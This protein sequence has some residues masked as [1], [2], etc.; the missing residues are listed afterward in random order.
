M[1]IV[2]P[3]LKR[4]V[5]PSLSKTGILRHAS[6]KG[7]AV[8]TYHGV[9]P[10]GYQ[11]IDEA[12]DGNLVT[13]EQL[14][15]QLRFLK[16]RYNVV[17]P[18]D[19]LAWREGRQNLPERAV[20]LTCDDGLLNHLTCLA[21]VLQE[22]KVSCLFFVTGAS[23]A[24]SRTMLWYE[25]MFLLFLRSP[26]GFHQVSCSGLVAD[27]ELHS[28]EQRRALWWSY[29][30]RLS[31]IDAQLRRNFL[32]ALE[33]AL[34]SK[35]LEAVSGDDSAFRQRFALLT[36]DEVLALSAA[37]MTIGAHTMS[38]PVLSQCSPDEAQNE[39]A[40]CRV[41]L[42]SVLNSRVWAFAYPFGDAQ[43]VT[44][45]VLKLPEAAGYAVAFMNHGGG[46]GVELPPFAFPRIHVT[47]QTN[48]AELEA[49]VSGFYSG[50]H[51]RLR[52]SA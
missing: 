31:K 32:D 44:P 41:R 49:H 1:K 22:E 5:Y 28:K 8:V 29:V 35:P 52:R 12:L 10:P 50:L 23:C 13:P 48:L 42:E 40:E 25:E 24:Q 26:A 33:A 39:I 27:I 30:K 4:V 20:L 43:S 19:V 11:P 18:Q 14:R 7:L 3:L 16:S 45:D 51:R 21:P 38:H 6:G 37:G 17:Q 47:A 15:R 34:G 9:V 46:L 2:S 36:R